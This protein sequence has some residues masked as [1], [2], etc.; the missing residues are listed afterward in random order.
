MAERRRVRAQ[1]RTA[2]EQARIEAI[3]EYFKDRPSREEL[4]AHTLQLLARRDVVDD[5][6][7]PGGG[8][9]DLQPHAGRGYGGGQ[10]AGG[11]V[12][13]HVVVERPPFL[14]HALRDV[15]VG[16]HHRGAFAVVNRFA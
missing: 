10:L 12:E 7:D 3:R 11:W 14:E 15:P 6:D 8:R 13:R 5:A 16:R 2:E 4:I 9:A 1:P